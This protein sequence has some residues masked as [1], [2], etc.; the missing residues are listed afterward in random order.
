MLYGY[1]VE[2]IAAG[3]A[4]STPRSGLFCLLFRS[5]FISLIRRFLLFAI[6][7]ISCLPLKQEAVSGLVHLDLDERARFVFRFQNLFG[8]RILYI[9]LDRSSEWSRAELLVETF[10]GDVVPCST[11]NLQFVTEVVDTLEQIL[12]KDIDDL[13]DVFLFEWSERS[14]VHTSERQARSHLVCR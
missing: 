4:Q 14:E 7:R 11:C 5:G 6:G 3:K 9:L 13:E 10:L 2:P 8:K 1:R 12:C